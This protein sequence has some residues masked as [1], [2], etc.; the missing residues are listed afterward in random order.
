[1]KNFTLLIKLRDLLFLICISFLL[2]AGGC[3]YI[4]S[5]IQPD[6][7]DV[8]ETFNVKI[9]VNADPGGE[10]IPAYGYVGVL[11][12]D[13]WKV[14]DSVRYFKTGSYS[15]KTG[16]LLYSDF[17]VNFIINQ[18]GLPPSGYYWWGARSM[19]PIDLRFDDKG[20]IDL[21]ITSGPKP[22]K[23]DTRYVL[24]DDNDWGENYLKISD[25]KSL[26]VHSR[27]LEINYEIN[28]YPNPATEHVTFSWSRNYDQLNLM[29]YQI[30]GK[31]LID[32]IISPNEETDVSHLPKGIYLYRLSDNNEM[33]KT[34][35]L[36]IE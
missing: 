14:K 26:I 18:V 23:F 33:I 3:Y 17:A 22:G 35:K 36:V 27:K 24:C 9:N 34:G 12:P 2:L 31:Y 30:T 29:V 16:Y 13:G 8:N 32:K 15:E 11:L 20:F 5:I 6:K 7:V 10:F 19:T 21:V 28:V 1:M 4:E 25:L